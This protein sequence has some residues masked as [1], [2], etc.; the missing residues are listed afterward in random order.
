MRRH[1]GVAVIEHR[2]EKIHEGQRLK[3][4]ARS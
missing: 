2:E 3:I 1:A 4:L